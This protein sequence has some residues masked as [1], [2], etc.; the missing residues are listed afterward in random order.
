MKNLTIFVVFLVMCVTVTMAQW[1]QNMPPQFPI[2]PQ[3][4][5]FEEICK[6]PGANCQSTSQVCDAFGKCKTVKN[7]AQ[8]LV[9]ASKF[10]LVTS[11]LLFRMYFS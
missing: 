10:L 1:N 6:Q 9:I 8:T 11:C 2:F 3:P 4:P 5:T 7:G